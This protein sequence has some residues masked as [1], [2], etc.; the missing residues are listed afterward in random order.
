MKT[1]KIT[2]FIALVAST[3]GLNSC[4]PEDDITMPNLKPLILNEDFSRGGVDNVILA[5]P[6]WTN[7][8]ET[9]TMKWKAQEFSGNLYAEFS[10][11]QSGE[12]VN[13][14]WLI[15][16]AIDLDKQEGEKLSFESAQSFV[17]NA[18]NSLEALISTDF[19]GT[20]VTT[21]TWTTIQ[22]TL[23]TTSST[24][25]QFIKSGEIDLSSYTG[26]AYIAF[27][28]KGSGT[29]TSLDGS[30]QIDNV[31]VYNK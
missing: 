4:S 16:P 13:V 19:D 22:A 17:T 21:A 12:A 26:K 8:A 15:S 5:T 31:K 24:Y 28:V 23:P 18:S 14:A 10:S 20:N 2:L 25:F 7:Y 1:N 6:G 9:G 3:L 11:F 29:N 30:Y 27:K